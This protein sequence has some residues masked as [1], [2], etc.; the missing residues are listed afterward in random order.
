MRTLLTLVSAVRTSTT[1]GNLLFYVTL[2]IGL[3]IPWTIALTSGNLEIPHNDSWAYSRI[4]Q[5]WS[6][7][8]EIK[9][10]GW[11]R[12]SLVGQFYILGPLAE[13][14]FYQQTFVT[15]L[16]G[17]MLLSIYSIL[18][19]HIGNQRAGF[20]I[21][22]ISVFPGYGLLSTSYMTDI[23]MFSA[24]FISLAIGAKS[25]RK[26]SRG[27]YLAAIIFG[28]WG[29]TI[30]EQ[31]IA[32][33]IAVF[34]T[35]LFLRKGFK[36]LSIGFC[37]LIFVVSLIAILFFEIWRSQLPWADPPSFTLR[38]NPLF[39]IASGLVKGW[40]TL[41]LVA[42]LAIVPHLSSGNITKKL[43]V[44]GL[45]MISMGIFFWM[46]PI[47]DQFFLPNYLSINGSYSEVLG[48]V[49][50]IYATSFWLFYVCL[51]L[52]LGALCFSLIVRAPKNTD[53]LLATFTFLTAVGI[54]L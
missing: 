23:P 38:N 2:I 40:F 51:A 35:F 44:P 3:L 18:R 32:A 52:F 10:L 27:L 20:A 39:S 48:P 7:T 45:M 24:I 34:I 53:P 16:S 19:I 5:T 21:L 29:V 28:L 50:K 12:A 17:L 33:P 9:L 15:I 54:A 25:F 46:W 47:P 42:G 43:F 1:T 8:G 31:A 49:S 14:L 37:S 6:E 11:N 36:K 4:A 26:D 13:S 41:S 22:L 30:R